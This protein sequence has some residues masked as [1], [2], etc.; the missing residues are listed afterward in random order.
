[1]ERVVI[2]GMGIISP[3][4]ND[5]E[6]FWTRLSR[7]ESGISLIDTL[8]TTRHKVKIAGSVSCI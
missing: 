2:T 8:D 5:V 1:M 6:T 3:L 7:G 4:G